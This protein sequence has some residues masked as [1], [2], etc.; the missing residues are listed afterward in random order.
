[1]LMDAWECEA[2]RAAVFGCAVQPENT[3]L[4]LDQL[5]GDRQT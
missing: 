4:P 3:T 2:K 1:M 5:P